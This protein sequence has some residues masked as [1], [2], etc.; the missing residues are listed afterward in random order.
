MRKQTTSTR[1]YRRECWRCPAR[2]LQNLHADV[3]V[4]N[5]HVGDEVGGA[6]ATQ[7]P[8]RLLIVLRTHPALTYVMIP[9]AV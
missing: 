8:P 5:Q 2:L 7:R 3:G 4:S 1:L 9:R 6:L